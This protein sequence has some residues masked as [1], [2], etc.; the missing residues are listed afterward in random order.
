[1]EWPSDFDYD[2]H[3]P[4]P[5]KRGTFKQEVIQYMVRLH[6]IRQLHRQRFWNDV[7][8][9]DTTALYIKKIV[10]RIRAHPVRE[11]TT[12]WIHKW[13]MLPGD[14]APDPSLSRANET[15]HDLEDHIAAYQ[16]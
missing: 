9:Y 11:S 1:M 13:R 6:F 16:W 5:P 3:R 8:P 2:A 15:P 10:G 7:G 14:T 12:E 4:P